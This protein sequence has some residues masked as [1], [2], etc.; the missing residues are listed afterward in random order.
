M[1]ASSGFV[2]DDGGRA[3]RGEAGSAEMAGAAD[4]ATVREVAVLRFSR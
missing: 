2:V 1:A 4:D 3:G